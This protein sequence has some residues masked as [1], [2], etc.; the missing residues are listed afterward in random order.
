MALGLHVGAHHAIGHD[1]LSVFGHKGRND[2]VKRPLARGD[3]I[4][5]FVKAK[6]MAPVLQADAKL[7]LDA[8][9]TKPHVVALNKAHH[10]AVFVCRAEVNRAALDRIARTKIL[11]L[12]HI[13]ELGAAGQVSVIQHLL[14]G[15]R[16]RRWLSHV[17]V[18]VGKGQLHGFN[19]QMLRVHTIYR[20]T[21]HI[22]LVQNA[23][24]N[25]R[26]NALAVRRDLVQRVA[27]VVFTDRFD[28]FRL[29]VSKVF[30]C[31]ATAVGLRELNDRLGDLATVKCAAFSSR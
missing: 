23:D 13:D 6:A 4:D 20:Q 31:V 10:H 28:P 7:R 1:G 14:W 25:Q 22:K 27:P 18:H 11:R 30:E 9:R 15:H 12:F 17:F 16:H 19:L 29:I 24:G 3:L 8:A 5:T 21:G 26:R 2:G